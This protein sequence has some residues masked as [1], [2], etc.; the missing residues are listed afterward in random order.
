MTSRTLHG[1]RGFTLIEVLVALS[2]VGMVFG[3]ALALGRDAIANQ[4]Y[5][6]RR[7]LAV[8]VADN[9]VATWRLE[10][11]VATASEQRG[12]ETLLG[13]RFD[14]VLQVN[15][16]VTADPAWPRHSAVVEVFEYGD[17]TALA[18]RQHEF[19]GP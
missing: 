1:A 16:D 9:V 8:W 4:D 15:E 14:Y 11:P 18:F 19:D 6:E 7:L 3:S 2:L 12:S 13:R 5:L 10:R 17:T